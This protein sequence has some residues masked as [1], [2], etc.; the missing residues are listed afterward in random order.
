MDLGHTL[1]FIL[2]FYDLVFVVV[3]QTKHT[4]KHTQHHVFFFPV[5]RRPLEHHY[6]DDIFVCLFEFGLYLKIRKQKFIHM[7]YEQFF[8]LLAIVEKEFIHK[9]STQ[10][11]IIIILKKWHHVFLLHCLFFYLLHTHLWHLTW[12]L[13]I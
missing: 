5:K 13:I 12:L 6:Y 9:L 4:Y 1:H 10:I 7:R 11:I 2:I 8:F 3:N